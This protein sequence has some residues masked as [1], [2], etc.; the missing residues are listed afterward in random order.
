MNK[1]SQISW[2]SSENV[3]KQPPFESFK[4]EDITDKDSIG[5]KLYLASIATISLACLTRLAMNFA[6]PSAPWLLLQQVQK[7]V[8]YLCVCINVTNE[9]QK[10]LKECIWI[11]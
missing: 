10:G 1:G 9:K 4:P 7:N 5:I 6:A 2:Y 8:K 11:E 3:C